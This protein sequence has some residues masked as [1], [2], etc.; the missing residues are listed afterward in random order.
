MQYMT[1]LILTC[2][3]TLCVSAVAFAQAE[4]LVQVEVNKG[5]RV[6]LPKAA[7]SVVAANPFI[8]DVQVVSPRVLYIYGKGVGETSVFAIDTEDNTIFDANVRVTHNI[9]SLDNAVKKMAPDADVQFKSVNGGLVME[10]FAS[11]VEE[12][13]NIRSMASNLVDNDKNQKL[14]TG[15]IV[16]MITTGGSDQ[17]T[18]Q[19]KIVEMA[20]TDVK[21][22]G[23]NLLSQFGNNGL[24]FQILQGNNITVN[25]SGILTRTGISVADAA[26]DTSVYARFAGITGVLD[27][28]E[29]Q[30]LATTL[31]EPTLT[32]S[33]G[34]TA[35]FLAGGE[36]PIP[37][38]DGLGNVSVTY[39]PFG[40]KLDFTPVVMSK[41][42]MS[43]TVAPEVSSINFDTT[44]ET[45]GI[46]NPTIN[47]RKAQATL[48]MGSGETFMLAGLLQN[49][50]SNAIDK[51]PGLGDMPV[52]GALMRSQQFR[53]NKTELVILVTPYIVRPVTESKKML[54]PY[55][56]YV[57]PTDL[58]R[59]LFGNLYQQEPME[60]DEGAAPAPVVIENDEKSPRLKGEGGFLLE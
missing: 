41:E 40:V 49:T 28:L 29:S 23:L 27:A 5:K 1:R 11:S 47:T 22:L 59:L 7:A 26:K 2:S 4:D 14:T 45:A 25:S 51:F 48:E 57:P 31:A 52:I 53:N 3:A 36:F 17:V 32:T 12:V 10:G 60:G 9:A 37:Q 21:R 56:G 20:R 8:A 50:E 42:R 38:K 34:K 16:N 24:G 33:S 39:K 15:S 44:I 18:L 54:T 30:G 46:R 6:T 43:I 13:E 58:Q 19:V 55:D 35:N